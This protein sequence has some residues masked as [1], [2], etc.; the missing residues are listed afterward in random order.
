LARNE[1]WKSVTCPSCGGAAERDTDT[2]DTFVDSSWYFARYCS[3]QAEEPLDPAQLAYWM[4][5][6]QYIGGI[7][8]A[9][10]HLLYSRFFMRALKGFGYSKEAEPFAALFTQGMIGHETYRDPE[11]KWLSPEEVERDAE[12]RLTTRDGR[13]VTLGRVEKMSKSKRNTVDP[14]AIIGT[15]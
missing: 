10:L 13:P 8:H 3:P 15:Y 14:T 12:G 1:A 2:M 4:P 11:G 6:D 5:V 7:E 9:I